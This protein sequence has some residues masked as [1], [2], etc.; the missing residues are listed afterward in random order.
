MG[1]A[2]ALL[3]GSREEGGEEMRKVAGAF[4]LVLQFIFAIA[5]TILVLPMAIYI[6]YRRRE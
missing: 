6:K 5:L 1:R 4:I 3:E 2:G